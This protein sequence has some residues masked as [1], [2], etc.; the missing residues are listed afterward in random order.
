MQQQQQP[1]RV[2]SIKPFVDGL[3]TTLQPIEVAYAYQKDSP[4]TKEIVASDLRRG[5]AFTGIKTEALAKTYHFDP[6]VVAAANT[7]LN[8]YKK[9]GK[10]V[11][12]LDYNKESE[13][14]DQLINDFETDTVIKAAIATL[15]LTAW[16][17]ELK[18]ANTKFKQK[19]IER[20]AQYATQPTEPAHKLRPAAVAAFDK[21]FA[22]INSRA[23]IRYYR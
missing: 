15:G 9:Y 13:T 21:L 5:R 10:R 4:Q 18:D 17:A 11:I 16:V 7:V 3:G 6:I 8:C 12:D 20:T 2:K 14:L 22:Q 19:Y 23:T 1:H